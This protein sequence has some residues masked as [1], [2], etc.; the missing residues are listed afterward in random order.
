MNC[1]ITLK[2]E[3]NKHGAIIDV[4]EQDYSLFF[5][6]NNIIPFLIPNTSTEEEIDQYFQMIP[7]EGIIFIGGNDVDPKMYGEETTRPLSLVPQRDKVELYLLKKAIKLNLPILGICRG[8]Q[9]I[10]V[11]LGGKLERNAHPIGEHLIEITDQKIKEEIEKEEIEEE[12]SEKKIIVNSFHNHSLT[13][14]KLASKLIPFAMHEKIIE[15]FYHSELPIIGIQWHPERKGS[16]EKINQ[17]IINTFKNKT[18][19]NKI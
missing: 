16:D 10:N 13:Q 8:M 4:L 15:G 3:K 9:F 17:L 1:L 6:K 12:K 18:I 2:Q 19:F 14:K 11:A 5:S 7:C